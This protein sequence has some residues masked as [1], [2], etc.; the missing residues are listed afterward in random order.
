MREV[1]AEWARAGGRRPKGELARPQVGGAQEGEKREQSS[2][3]KNVRPHLL[4]LLRH[5]LVL[6][7]EV[8]RGVNRLHKIRVG[9][10]RPAPHRTAVRSVRPPL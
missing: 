10:S 1:R 4:A 6:L 5:D 3:L 2:R 8:F 7:E 9:L